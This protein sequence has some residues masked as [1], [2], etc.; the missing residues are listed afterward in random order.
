MT[1][2]EKN[3]GVTTGSA[4]GKA[5]RLAGQ[6]LQRE[7]GKPVPLLH[8]ISHDSLR[9]SGFCGAIRPRKLNR[10]AFPVFRPMITTRSPVG[11]PRMFG[12][13]R[14]VVWSSRPGSP[15]PRTN[16][17]LTGPGAFSLSPVIPAAAGTQSPFLSFEHAPVSGACPRLTFLRYHKRVG[18]EK[19]L[20]IPAAA[21][22]TGEEPGE[23]PGANVYAYPGA[24]AL[25]KP[26]GT[27][28][29]ILECDSP[30]G[31]KQCHRTGGLG[32]CFHPCQKAGA[33]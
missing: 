22:M 26:A 11:N 29:P 14:T 13:V 16:A 9:S 23:S 8:L 28:P 19:G 3:R 10:G 31:L 30:A 15:R 12:G 21:R 6:Q 27:S 32:N 25:M 2:I 17:P 1:A 7:L 4:V 24:N 20:W 5:D 33:G 18:A